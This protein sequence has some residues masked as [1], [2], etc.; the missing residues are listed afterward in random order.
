MHPAQ[1]SGIR[2]SRYE[3]P[4]TL[5][6]ALRLLRHWGPRAKA[7]AGGTDVLLELGRGVHAGVEV[8]V[9]LTR[10]A[11]L[12]RIALADQH[13]TIG[14]LVTHNQAIASTTVVHHALPLAQACL[15]IGAPALRNRATIVGNI[16]TASPANDTIPA[17]WALNAVLL[18][19]SIDRE[20][21]VAIR[22]FFSGLRQTVLNPDELVTSI[23]IPRVSNMRGIFVKLGQRRAQAISIVSL[24]I[25]V[26]L[27][28]RVVRSASIALGSVAATAIGAPE[29]E[30]YL[31][32][33][34]LDDAVISQAADLVAEALHP[35]DDIRASATYR[36]DQAVVMV[37]RALR[38]LC[39]DSQRSRWP[40]QPILLAP[41]TEVRQATG[42]EFRASHTGDTV[43]SCLINGQAV[44]HNDAINR[45]LVD[46]L[47][48]KLGLTG[49][50]VGC[51]EGECGACT[52]HLDGVAV[53]GCLVPAVRAHGAHVTTIE[54]IGTREAMHPLQQ[55]FIDHFA[56]QCGYCTPGFVMAGERLVKECA[57]PT[58]EQ[59]AQGLSGNLC[60]CTGY[61]R[62]YD[63]IGGVT[64]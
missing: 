9:D 8:L 49:T 51:A 24:A 25:A 56:V 44:Q 6:E 32:G 50:K 5:E 21:R 62:F 20:R 36:R 46:W 23:E 55:A 47:R 52:V 14:P 39:H 64:R 43:V 28:D 13:L 45:T 53:L 22:D 41:D 7:V 60:R 37:K 54:G 34:T 26:T 15:E 18:V 35:I 1:S 3:T 57:H 17:L 29:A 58:R 12:D 40:V 2:L 19:R 16:V 33:R 59:I 61:Y 11:G 30:N 42:P 48:L 4:G 31:C 10:I 38:S 27:T 63:A